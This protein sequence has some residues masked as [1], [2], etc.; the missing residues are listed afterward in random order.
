MRFF[1]DKLDKTESEI[2]KEERDKVLAQF[3][4]FAASENCP[5]EECPRL[6]GEDVWGCVKC[7]IEYLRSDE[8]RK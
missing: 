2:R 7:I 5:V 3:M 4:Q 1:G 8:G 6:R